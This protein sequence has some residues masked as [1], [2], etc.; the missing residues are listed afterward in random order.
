MGDPE[1][2]IAGSPVEGP[3]G[4]TWV[5]AGIPRGGGFWLSVQVMSCMG[6]TVCIT[7]ISLR[8]RCIKNLSSIDLQEVRGG[9]ILLGVDCT[10]GRPDFVCTVRVHRSDLR[11]KGA[12]QDGLAL[13]ARA[14]VSAWT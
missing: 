3:G 13:P 12:G 5:Q 7:C 11:V 2:T 8:P 1:V 6:A 9:W 10:V 4:G 14:L